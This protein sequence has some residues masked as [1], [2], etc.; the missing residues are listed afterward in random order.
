[1]QLVKP[2]VQLLWATIDP[3][4][5]IEQAG[6]TCYKSED[7]ISEGSAEKFVRML[8]DRGH[9]AMIEHA[10]MSMRFICDRGVTHEIVRHRLFSYAQE[11]TR[12]CN[13]KGGVTFIIPCWMQDRLEEDTYLWEECTFSISRANGP[14][15]GLMEEDEIW[16]SAMIKSE[17][18]YLDLVSANQ[19]PQQARSVLPNSLKTEIVVTGNLRE[20]RHFFMLRCAKAAHPQ[21]REVAFMALA[22]AK[23]Q[24]PVIFDEYVTE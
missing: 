24:V 22:I 4:K 3:L 9:E 15:R 2:S 11:S 7:K 23:E 18:S 19:T 6:R 12:Y 1:M 5:T 21:M 10:S 20:W 16:L 8:I 14:L 17:N 13:Y